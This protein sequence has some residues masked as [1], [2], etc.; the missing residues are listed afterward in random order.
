MEG[1]GS[2]RLGCRCLVFIFALRILRRGKCGR[3]DQRESSAVQGARGEKDLRVV[4][5]PIMMARVS[6]G[7]HPSSPPSAWLCGLH[8]GMKHA[9]RGA[10]WLER[11]RLLELAANLE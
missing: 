7:L 10:R 8:G 1:H 5:V 9:G 4:S 2:C 3:H 6:C 11:G